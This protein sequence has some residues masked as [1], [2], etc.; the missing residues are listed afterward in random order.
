MRL[1]AAGWLG[2]RDE[3]F[4]HEQVDKLRA[5]D[6]TKRFHYAGI[7]DRQQKLAFLRDLD[8]LS[9]P[10]VYHEPKGLFV[11]EAWASGLPVIQPDHGAF[12]ELLAGAAAGRL[13]RPGDVGHLTEVLCELLLDGTARHALGANGKLAVRRSFSAE[14]AALRTLDVYSQILGIPSGV[15]PP[16]PA[17][18]A[19]RAP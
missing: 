15:L 4:F 9:V 8:L 3:A 17:T 13:V 11:L 18:A 10:T 5:P 12:P 6:W 19:S 2:P 7:V 16:T 14:S 1:H